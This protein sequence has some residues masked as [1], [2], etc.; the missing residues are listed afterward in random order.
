VG[1]ALGDPAG[2]PPAGEPVRAAPPGPAVAE[3]PGQRAAPQKPAAEPGEG[4]R[5]AA[6]EKPLPDTGDLILLPP[7][8]LASVRRKAAANTPEWRALKANLDRRLPTVISSGYQ[9]AA[10][11]WIANYA[12]GYQVLKDR[13]PAAASAYA[14]K[15]IGLMKSALRDFQKANWSGIQFLA[16]GDGRTRTFTL[17]HADVVPS[18]FSVYLAPVRITK[19]VHRQVD[20]QEPVLPYSK[21]LKVSNSADGPEDYAEGA[22]WLHDGNYAHDLID[23]SPAGKEPERGATYYVT[24]VSASDGQRLPRATLSGRTLTLAEAPPAGK[25]VFVEYVHGTHQADGSSLAYQQTGDGCGGFNSILIDSGY[26]ARYLGRNVA[27]ARDWLDGYPG[28]TPA[29][30]AEADGMLIR[31]SDYCRDHAYHHNCLASNYGDGEYIGRVFT[32]LALSRRHKEGPRLLAEVV[33]FRQSK[34]PPLLEGAPPSLKG[35]FWDEGWNYG[36]LSAEELLLSGLA[37]EQRGM[38]PAARPERHWASEVVFQLVSAQPA[39]GVIYNGGDW[40]LYPAPFPEQP[41]L[42]VLAALADDPAARSYANYIVRHDRRTSVAAYPLALLLEDPSAPAS[43]WSALPL[44]H[45]APGTGLLTARSDWG[46][47][48]TW[49]AFQLGNLLGA[50]HQSYAPGLLQVQRGADDLLINGCAPVGVMDHRTKSKFSNVIVVDA[51]GDRV[52]DYPANMGVWYGEPGVVVNA[53][54]P[55]RDH[56]YISGDYHAAYSPKESPGSGGPAREL[57]RQVVYVRPNYVFVYDRVATRK[58]SYTNQQRWHF[59]HAPDVNG[60]AFVASAGRSKLFGQTFSTLPLSAAVTAAK[61]Y[62][63]Y[64]QQLNIQTAQPAEAVRYATALQTAPAATRGMD[65]VRHV[66]S[67]DRAMEG[68]RLGNQLVL[69]GVDGDLKPGTSVRYEASGDAGLHHL[70]VNLRPGQKYQVKVNGSPLPA[71]TAT[72]QG[73]IAFVAPEKVEQKVEVAEA[74]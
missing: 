2:Q 50:N 58:A 39:S 64:V 22:D 27:L 36:A 45:F 68:V 71:V 14:D 15:A 12:L 72:E 74:P 59:Q 10:L 20:G 33:A 35:G 53:H 44:Q 3:E 63:K 31:W 8:T 42:L 57:T 47:S 60:T 37:L 70:L 32:A 30:K 17:P 51:H 18:S 61:A 56:V 6:D 19:V 16:R 24:S 1:C 46:E 34:I 41:L 62:G 69:F 67:L 26:T 21:F 54:E 40:Y 48:P 25:A 9:A 7:K 65:P 66:V 55:A 23:W 38:I 52:Q 4:G 73:T 13:D 11:Q 29:L 49:I 5:V 28:L 43:F